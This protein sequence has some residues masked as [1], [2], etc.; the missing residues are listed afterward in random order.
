MK[1]TAK[2]IL[3]AL[4]ASL[5]CILSPLSIPVGSV[6]IS[7]ATMAIFVVSCLLGTRSVIPVCLYLSLG[8]FGVPVFS[9]GLGGFSVI[10]G[11]TGGYLVGYIPCAF[12]SGWILER[13]SFRSSAIPF[14][15]AVGNVFVYLCGMAWLMCSAMSHVAV[16]RAVFA[17]VLPFLPGDILKI[18]AASMLGTALRKRLHLSDYLQS[19]TR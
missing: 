11:P 12:V 1:K 9:G 13:L 4:F 14:A 15:F 7:L 18:A 3:Y 2:L 8:I 17:G 10:L 5:F 19:P 6:P 16:S